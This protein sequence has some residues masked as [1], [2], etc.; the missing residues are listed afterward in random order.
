[1]ALKRS[2]VIQASGDHYLP[3][4]Q[5]R[6]LF[7]PDSPTRRFLTIDARNHRFNGGESA[8]SAALVEA[9]AWVSSGGE[10]I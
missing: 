10:G 2:V 4:A 7:G 6:A 1:M 3:A 9:V 5:A 8:F